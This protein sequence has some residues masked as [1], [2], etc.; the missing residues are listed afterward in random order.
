MCHG[1]LACIV[2]E[3]AKCNNKVDKIN[4]LQRNSLILNRNIKKKNRQRIYFCGLLIYN[5]N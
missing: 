1:T 4:I 2:L 3:Y 5:L